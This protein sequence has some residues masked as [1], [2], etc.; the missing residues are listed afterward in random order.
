MIT[1][2]INPNLN[3]QKMAFCV[4][5]LGLKHRK[6]RGSALTLISRAGGE[7][8]GTVGDCGGLRVM[9]HVKMIH[10]RYLISTWLLL[11]VQA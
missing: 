6:S 2:C 7:L 1:T 11:V 3:T 9:S 8:Q 10:W 5:R 4:L